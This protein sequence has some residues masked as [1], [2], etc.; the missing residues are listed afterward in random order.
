MP[1]SRLSGWRA[2]SV[3]LT[4]LRTDRP[5]LVLAGVGHAHLAVLEAIRRGGIPPCELIVC[6]GE[7]RHAY[8]GMV[9]GWL[10]GVYGDDEVTLDVATLVRRAG[11]TLYASNVASLVPSRRT[12]V[13]ADGREV[14][15]DTC[16]IA[17]GSLPS[18]RDLP[19]VVE[20]SASVK[21]WAALCA[22]AARLDRL[23]S[24]G[25]HVCVV[26][27]GL[28]GVEVAL[29]IRARLQGA[30]VRVRL[31][32]A[33][34][35]LAPDRDARVAAQLAVACRRHD[36]DVTYE[37]VVSAVAPGLVRMRDASRA[38]E[39]PADVV[40][41][42]AGAGAPVWLRTSGLPVDD[43]GF[44]QVD[45]A[46]RSRGDPRVHAAGDTASLPGP[47]GAPK[48]GVYAVRMGPALVASLR[49]ALGGD[50]P[51]RF[52]PQRH[53]LA[54]VNLGDGRALASWRGLVAGGRWAM[55]W[56]DAIDRS[57]LARYRGDD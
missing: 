52:R 23:R 56:K 24:T 43:R 49:H 8:S 54:L 16:S 45:D 14:R 17:V 21:P 48:A 1:L 20:Y 19:G 25:G 46:L 28:A 44:L 39:V 12:L 50:G 3:P 11:G 4:P 53:F 2:R 47:G 36:V 5:R 29:A 42:L 33:D 18:G 37:S 32:T 57:F 41:W 22:L 35:R 55:R 10:A 6:T 40:V 13:L 9:P 27:G 51:G 7:A 30:D 26:G 34:A 38:H 15:Y 31:L